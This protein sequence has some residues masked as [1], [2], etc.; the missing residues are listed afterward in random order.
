MAGVLVPKHHEQPDP[1]VT[2]LLRLDGTFRTDVPHG[3][4]SGRRAKWRLVTRF[5][6]APLVAEGADEGTAD[7]KWLFYYLFAVS[8]SEPDARVSSLVILRDEVEK[9]RQRRLYGR[10]G[11]QYVGELA[12]PLRGSSSQES[13]LTRY[14]ERHGFAKLGPDEY[15]WFR[16]K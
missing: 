10:D 11:S 12:A 14:L 13:S 9:L 3:P 8:Q 7:G 1:A 15:F 6:P 16:P 4:V 5:L 2:G